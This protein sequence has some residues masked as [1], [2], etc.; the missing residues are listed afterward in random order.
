MGFQIVNHVGIVVS[1]LHRSI[2]F[3][4]A[5][6]GVAVAREDVVGGSRLAALRGLPNLRLGFAMVHLGNI[7]IEL[8]QY[9][10]PVAD[11]ARYSA[12]DISSMHLAFEVEDL[13]LVCDRMEKSGIPIAAG[14][15]TLTKDDLL[16]Y[17]TGTKVAY[18]DDPDGT[19]LEVVEPRGI[20]RR[21]D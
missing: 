12:A 20:F 6:T 10:D 11:Q 19:H 4:E 2:R 17:G 15:I 8:V 5:L 16:A 14:P 3:Y 21:R 1:D 13:P 9:V 7:N 18:F